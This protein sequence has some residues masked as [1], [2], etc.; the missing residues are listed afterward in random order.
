MNKLAIALAVAIFWPQLSG[1][2]IHSGGSPGW[3][4]PGVAFPRMGISNGL[5]L[6]F[7]PS[8]NS[9]NPN[10]RDFFPA[11]FFF[12]PYFYEPAPVQ[13]AA[14]TVV[15]VPLQLAP[16]EEMREEPKSAAPLL[17][18]R[19]GDRFLRFSGEDVS[20]GSSANR[21]Y[22][23]RTVTVNSDHQEPA[24]C[25]AQLPPA[26]LVFRD[27][28]REQ[29]SDYAIMRGEIYI[30]HDL[31]AGS[32]YTKFSLADLDLIATAEENRERGSKFQLPRGPNEI[33]I[34]P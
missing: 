8:P 11:G 27:G 33:V 31:E 22:E 20:D 2:Q 9:T 29:T 28:H 16:K 17:I 24:S 26:V 34:R 14:P 25:P 7:G 12:D 1:A 3:T 15:V 5:T 21:K 18:E 32:W 30:Y 4:Q 23:R 19:D 10:R 6:S 13:T